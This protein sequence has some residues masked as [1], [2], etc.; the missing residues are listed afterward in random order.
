MRFE[1]RVVVAMSAIVFSACLGTGRTPSI[2]GPNAIATLEEVMIGGVPQS[3]L[4]RGVDAKGPVLLWLHGGPGGTVMPVAHVFGGELEK[5]FVVVHWDQRGSGLSARSDVPDD[6]LNLEQFLSDTHELIDILRSRFGVDR[7]FLLG[8]SWGS[9]LG[10]ITA[11]RHPDLLHAYIGMGQATDER[12]SEELGLQWVREQA[13]LRGEDRALRELE[14]LVPPYLDNPRMIATQRKWLSLFGGQV[15]NGR[16]FWVPQ[17]LRP[18]MGAS[19]H[20]LPRVFVV[21]PSTVSSSE[22]PSSLGSVSRVQGDQLHE[23]RPSYRGPG[24]FPHGPPRLQH[25]ALASRGV[26]RLPRRA[27]GKE[28]HLV[29]R[30]STLPLPRGTGA[31]R[32]SHGCARA[33]RKA[34]R[35]SEIRRRQGIAVGRRPVVISSRGIT[36]RRRQH[37]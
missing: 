17:G 1:I 22:L 35:P 9:V 12:R 25:A 20:P 31:F 5:H 33:R 21:R 13:A 34:G 30:V 7:I 19:C 37:H 14:G 6:S 10:L 29:R 32:R 8:H 28:P 4:V 3:I 16:P 11:Q 2:E 18:H 27:Q 36:G 26:L 23:D 15:H 24:L